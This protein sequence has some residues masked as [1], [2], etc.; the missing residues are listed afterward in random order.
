MKRVLYSILSLLAMLRAVAPVDA[1]EFGF[2]ASDFV[3]GF[4]STAGDRRAPV[5]ATKGGCDKL[6]EGRVSCP[7]VIN[8]QIFGSA[9]GVEASALAEY[10]QVVYFPV[11][12]SKE[13]VAA[14]VQTLAT[15]VEMLT[16]VR[17]ANGFVVALFAR[18]KPEGG[19]K[20]MLA[21][22]GVSYAIIRNNEGHFSFLAFPT[23]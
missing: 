2:K 9:V 12:R 16:P 23:K 1:A 22:S 5:R 19:S 18:L 11:T 15:I 8:D 3:Q 20:S 10:I 21:I 6:D 4:N 17:D 14:L 13:E 7:F